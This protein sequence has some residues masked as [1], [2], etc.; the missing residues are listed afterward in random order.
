M[1]FIAIRNIYKT[2]LKDPKMSLPKF[3]SLNVR[4]FVHYSN[5]CM[6]DKDPA[7]WSGAGQAAMREV[8]ELRYS[9]LPHLYTLYYRAHVYNE[10]VLRPLFFVYADEHTSS[11]LSFK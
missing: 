10:L 5:Q 1:S 6:Q 2:I 8:T 9:L 3:F 11:V 4:H 7:V